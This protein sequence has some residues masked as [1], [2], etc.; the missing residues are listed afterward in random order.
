MFKNLGISLKLA[1][2]F[3]VLL[4][5][6]TALSSTSLWKLSH[7]R[8]D[9]HL[10]S[11]DIMVRALL[12]K[13]IEASI[14]ERAVMVIRAV[15]GSG[16]PAAL[17][18]AMARS[19]AHFDE[20]L[21]RLDTLVDTEAGQKL[22][23]G[24]K[25]AGQALAQAGDRAI[26]LAAAKDPKAMAFVEA[27]YLPAVAE[28]RKAAEGI[29]QRQLQVKKDAV[30]DAEATFAW[31]RNAL[32]G[33]L[34]AALLLSTALAWALTRAIA[35]PVRRAAAAADSITRGELHHVIEPGGRDETGQLLKAMAAMQASLRQA[36]E[37]AKVNLRVKAALDA[38]S[39]NVMIADVDGTIVYG[40]KAVVEMLSRN[41]P[42]IRKQLPQFSAASFVG[43]SF[44][45]FHRNPAHQRSMLSALRDVYQTEIKVGRCV[46][47][48]SACPVYDEAGERAGTVVEW[49]D[50][51]AEVEA[52][53][54]VSDIVQSAALGDFSGR[55]QEEGKQGFF[56][57]LAQQVNRLVETSE[58]GLSD[59]SRVLS[60]L[61]S[62]DLGPRI[63]AEYQGLFGTLKSDVNRTMDQLSQ[64]IGNVRG[65]ADALSAASGQVSQTAQ[66]LS[67]GATE[68]AASVEQT[69][70]S[71]QQM[72][73]SI[74]QNADNAKVTDTIASKAAH[75]AGEGGEAVQRTVD[76]MKQIAKRISIINDIAY[77]T[78]LLA[79]NAA[80]EAARAGEHGNGFAVVAAEVRKLAERSQVAATEIG[81]LASDSVGT[82][83]RAGSLLTAMV[84]SISKTSELVQEI[85]AASE[86]QTEGVSQINSAMNQLS[87]ATQ[88]TASASEELAATAE[89]LSG[90][91]EQL[92]QMMAFFSSTQRQSA[93]AG[94]SRAAQPGGHAVR[95]AVQSV[96]SSALS[97]APTGGGC[98]AHRS[99]TATSRGGHAP[100]L[101]GVDESS[102]T[103]F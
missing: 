4:L 93:P 31:T 22:V 44:D 20:R 62:G 74:R 21:A 34:A 82:A 18:E 90:Q 13:E 60:A 73:G 12:A 45:Q 14:D 25:Q 8:G 64:T 49:R 50:R 32:V 98:P 61:A 29:V 48:L 53:T 59:V 52:E 16:D 58:V 86:E 95:R 36:A 84:P 87:Q 27:T 41:E 15:A 79:L 67:Q 81:Q 102:F 72:S 5:L 54:E 56:L 89:E 26:A 103:R 46:F 37:A 92:Q 63:E 33:G 42:E 1:S 40:N 28:T 23:D 2:G 43:R 35:R 80:I 68:Q 100:A 11:D 66:S 69:T 94:A 57:R 85:A 101:A 39:T 6:M 51:T 24:V 47:S 9:V 17:R 76:A 91:A 78:N 38:S 19:R 70:A 7:M 3:A 10:L 71:M 30:D 97:G 55:V 83:E 88:Q 77:Q 65:A 75:E 99:G 96:V